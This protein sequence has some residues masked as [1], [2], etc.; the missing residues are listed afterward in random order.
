MNNLPKVVTQRCLEQDLNPRPTDRKSNATRCTT[1]PP[2]LPRHKILNLNK[3][4]RT[5]PKPKPTVIFKNCSYVCAYHCAQLSYT[6]QN[7]T[8]NFPLILQTI[9]IAQ[10][11]S[12]VG[13]RKSM[14][15][16]VSGTVPIR[17]QNIPVGHY[18]AVQYNMTTSRR[19][20]KQSVTR[21]PVVTS[22]W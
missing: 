9:I 16:C 18:A 14:T 12:T 22:L 21:A 7:R 6:T 2:T 8:D 15:A 1:A 20:V 19:G 5:K 4:T 11:M 17:S 10:M 13:D 3:C